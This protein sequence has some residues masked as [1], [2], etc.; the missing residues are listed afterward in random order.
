MCYI[1]KPNPGRLRLRLRH[2][3]YYHLGLM[4]LLQFLNRQ[5]IGYRHRH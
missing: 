2:L 4:T 3:I 5:L 1:W